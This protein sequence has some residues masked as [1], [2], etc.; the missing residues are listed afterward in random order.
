MLTGEAP[1]NA[2]P[3]GALT[4]IGALGHEPLELSGTHCVARIPVS[5]RHIAVVYAIP[6]QNSL[7]PPE[8][9]AA[10][11]RTI[12]TRARPTNFRAQVSRTRRPANTFVFKPGY[13]H[14]PRKSGLTA[15]ALSHKLSLLRRGGALSMTRKSMDGQRCRGTPGPVERPVARCGD[16]SLARHAPPTAYLA[17]RSAAGPRGL[18]SRGDSQLATPSPPLPLGHP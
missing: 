9:H 11:A 6:Q 14:Q 5:K 10:V 3:P 1:D 12:T 7:S 17:V 2:A 8:P 16:S 18:D 15:S 4:E 13:A